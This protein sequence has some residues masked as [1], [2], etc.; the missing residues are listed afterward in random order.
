[1]L[2]GANLSNVLIDSGATCNLMGQQTWNWL[3][4]SCIQCESRRSAK[5]LFAYVGTEPLPTLGMFSASVVSIGSNAECQAD[6]VVIKSDGRTLLGRKTAE[7][8]SLLH[9]GPLQSNSVI[10]EHSEDDIRQRYQ[11]QDRQIGLLKDYELKLHVDELV[12]PVTQPGYDLACARKW[13][14]S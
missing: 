9:V 6:F 12:K 8:L 7:V 13:T 2:G 1:M 3:K 14:R 4:A 11:D 10:C 5:V